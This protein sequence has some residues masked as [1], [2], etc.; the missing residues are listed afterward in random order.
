VTE[1]L[2]PL[3][4]PECPGYYARIRA[5][6]VLGRIA[7]ARRE[8]DQARARGCNPAYIDDALPPGTGSGAGTGAGTGG[9][10]G[11]AHCEDLGRS[12]S[13]PLFQG[14]LSR[15]EAERRMVAAGCGDQLDSLCPWGN[16][17]QNTYPDCLGQVI[18]GPGPSGGGGGGG[19]SSG[20]ECHVEPL[21][22]QGSVTL[23]FERRFERGRNLYVI[24]CP[25]DKVDGLIDF[26]RTQHGASL[27]RRFDTYQDGLAEARRRCR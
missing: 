16:F 11:G 2:R 13:E 6:R 3:D 19:S 21:G 23:L 27:V 14:Q 7:D 18:V 12:L 10:G 1:A 22:G 4:P 5:A 8:A 20:P 26:F 15:Q 9:G 17:G 24:S 25:P